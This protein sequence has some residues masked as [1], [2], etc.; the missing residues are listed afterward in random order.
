MKEVTNDLL[1]KLV[2]ELENKEDFLQVRD[3]LLKRGIESLLKAEMSAHLGYE[4]GKVPLSDNIR[5]GYSEKTIKSPDGSHRIKIPRDRQGS[6]DP[7]IVPKHK[8]M[9]EELADC[10]ILLY[11]KGMS[12]ADIVD[13][14]EQTYGVKYSS[15]QVSIITNSLLED[16]RNW[17]TRPLEDQYAV[18]WIDAI[19]YKI[20]QDGKVISKAGMI[21][22]GIDMEGQQDV[23]S[24]YIVENECAA[25]WT[26]IL[27]DLKT[28]GVQDILFLCSD[29]LTGLQKSVEAIFPKSVHQ[30]CIVHQI[31]NSLKFVSYKD[32]RAIVK[33][34]KGIYRADNEPMARQ[35]FDVFKQN[36]NDKYPLAV[37]SWDNNWEHLT[38]FLDYPEEIRK[39]I[40]TTNI[41]ESFNASLRKFTKNKRV[42]PTDDAALKS[43]YLAA[44]QIRKKWCKKR[45]NWPQIYSQLAIYFENRIL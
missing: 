39:L 30:I 10:V 22:L 24:I 25:A 11:A 5:N 13:F 45:F 20:R 3:Q 36:W 43:I 40:Y 28:R 6:F 23:L 37:K 21:V 9:S 19:H 12:N 16:I 14:L 42:F 35:A 2:G 31:R 38:A 1:D 4:P 41:I 18:V 17:Q 33:D 15:A 34:I 26:N 32:R 7:L 27:D 44:Q 29:N 8:S